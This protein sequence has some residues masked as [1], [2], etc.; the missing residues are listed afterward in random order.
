MERKWTCALKWWFGGQSLWTHTLSPVLVLVAMHL[1]KAAVGE[2]REGFSSC[3]RVG[4]LANLLALSSSCP[5]EDMKRDQWS[6]GFGEWTKTLM[7]CSVVYV[8]ISIKHSFKWLECCL[9]ETL[10]SRCCHWMCIK[11]L[12]GVWKMFLERGTLNTSQSCGMLLADILCVRCPDRN[13]NNSHCFSYWK[14]KR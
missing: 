4:T 13:W 10:T 14:L 5:W 8:W 9:S 1:W 12:E 11:N 7:F 3:S 6:P 2:R